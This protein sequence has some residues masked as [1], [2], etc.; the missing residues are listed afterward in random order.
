MSVL[1]V[2]KYNGQYLY[3]DDK[4]L[5]QTAEELNEILDNED[6]ESYR[7]RQAA[8]KLFGIK[9]WVTGV[10]TAPEAGVEFEYFDT[11]YQPPFFQPPGGDSNYLSQGFGWI[12]IVP[13]S[14]YGAMREALGYQVGAEPINQDGFLLQRMYDIQTIPLN[15][16]Y[17]S[18]DALANVYEHMTPRQ[19]H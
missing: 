17:A 19:W 3:F 12:A 14:S 6:S 5:V 16:D 8:I 10:V 15:N 2:A 11:F 7:A 9:D 13:D 18:T 1:F 4:H